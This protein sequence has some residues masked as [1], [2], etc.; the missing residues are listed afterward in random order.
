MLY[1]TTIV[2]NLG[3]SM[4]I[5]VSCVNGIN[6]V[7]P[8]LTQGKRDRGDKAAMKGANHLAQENF[9]ARIEHPS[10]QIPKPNA[11]FF[12]VG[13]HGQACVGQLVQGYAGHIKALGW[14]CLGVGVD[15]E[16]LYR[17]PLATNKSLRP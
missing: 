9:V 11:G 16:H 5:D 15:R 13:V 7:F 17:Q 8:C 10:V 1:S 14:L 6:F 2:V 4:V 12:L 3:V